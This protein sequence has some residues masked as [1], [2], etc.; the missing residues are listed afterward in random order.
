MRHPWLALLFVTLPAWAVDPAATQLARIDEHYA[1]GYKDAFPQEFT[2]VQT[3]VTSAQ[4]GVAAKLGLQVGQGFHHP[5][6]VRFE[7]GVPRIN[8]N[9]F[10]YVRTKGTGDDFH[11]ELVA[12]V[13]AFAKPPSD[14]YADLRGGFWYAMAQLMLND[15][16]AGDPESALPLWLQ[17][18][19]SV[20]A[21]GSGDALL[22]VVTRRLPKSRVR[23][24]TGGLNDPGPYLTAPELARYFLAVDFI[25][26]HGVLQTFLA[27]ITNGESPADAVRSTFGYEWPAFESNVRHF[28]AERLA[29]YA[30]SDEELKSG[31]ERP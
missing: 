11:Q 25:A 16:S 13:E 14:A 3:Y 27:N 7:D 12:N 17:E 2:T 29:G 6:T 5:V 1:G 4:S 10:F 18:G 30:P 8:Q 20:Y 19:L 26:S 28:S 21:S 22:K 9:P 15:L 23:E 31:R 24:L